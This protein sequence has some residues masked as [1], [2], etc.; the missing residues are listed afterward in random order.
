MTRKF[1]HSK[2]KI[3]KIMQIF[4]GK[5]TY[6]TIL[7]I[8]CVLTVCKCR[9]Y[10]EAADK[11]CLP[12][13]ALSKQLKAV[14]EELSIQ[15]FQKKS[16]GIELTEAG[17]VLYPH[18]V[19]IYNQYKKMLECLHEISVATDGTLSLGSMYFLKYYDIIP[20]IKEFQKVQPRIHIDVGEYR[21]QE[22]EHLLKE[23]K[24]DGCFVYSELLIGEYGQRI[25]I[26]EDYLY[27]VMSKNHYLSN[28]KSIRLIELKDECFVLMRGDAGIHNQLQ[29]FCIEDG[30]VPREYN[31]DLRNETIKE[32]IKYNDGVSL[33]MGNMADELLDAH[34]VKIPIEGNK[35]LTVS[36]VV[37]N[38]TEVC[39]LFSNYVVKP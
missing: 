16:H 3:L 35:K 13:S 1:E 9:K 37:A 19:Y 36:F 22:L 25:P 7:Q 21:S 20:I 17:A 8:K 39:N 31:M 4:F 28:R 11:L 18:M 6:M 23:G 27:A 15:L 32:W 2:I 26:M 10:S 34:L 14:E 38:D 24:L 29:K 12:Q 33:F 5:G 30:F